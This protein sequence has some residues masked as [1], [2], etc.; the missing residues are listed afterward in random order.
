MK[1]YLV[2]G[3]GI[4]L[5]VLVACFDKKAGTETTNQAPM[6]LIILAEHVSELPAGASVPVYKRV[7]LGPVAGYEYRIQFE[8]A[9]G[10]QL[11]SDPLP[12]PWDPAL[13]DFMG[14]T[15]RY[16]YQKRTYRILTDSASVK[17][18]KDGTLSTP[19]VDDESLQLGWVEWRLVENKARVVDLQGTVVPGK[20]S[21]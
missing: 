5:A 21:P 3:L 13:G 16:T 6:A 18:A 8:W 19:V 20:G 12:S 7:V 11:V 15:L 10:F 1:F 4:C 2:L 17:R 14:A 9:D